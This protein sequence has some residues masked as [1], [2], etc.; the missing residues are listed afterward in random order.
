MI[1]TMFK[2]IMAV[3]GALTLA[4][5]LGAAP[6]Q[7]AAS[8]CNTIAFCIWTG[9]NGNFTGSLFKFS[10]GSFTAANNYSIRLGSGVSNRGSSFVNDTTHTMYLFDTTNC[11]HDGTWWRS[12]SPGQQANAVGSDWLNRVSSIGWN[13]RTDVP[14]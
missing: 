3:A 8:D 11:T 12:M 14:C 5:G 13:I 4:V 1:P 10:Q 6:A 9:V 7:A 2:R